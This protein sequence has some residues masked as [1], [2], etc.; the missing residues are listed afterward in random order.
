[1]EDDVLDLADP[2]AG[3]D[4]DWGSDDP[5]A[6][7]SGLERSSLLFWKGL[8]VGLWLSAVAWCVLA[9]VALALYNV[10]TR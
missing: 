4:A 5:A 1:M 7:T 8:L 2:H 6:V 3:D 10:V 9:A